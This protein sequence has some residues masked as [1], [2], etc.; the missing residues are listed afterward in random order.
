ME[1]T[2]EGETILN[3]DLKSIENWSKQWLVDFNPRKTVAMK[4]SLKTRPIPDPVL[5]FNDSQ[6]QIVASHKH[7]GLE[8][9]NK[10]NW[11]D[12]ITTIATKANRKLDN[13]K[14]LRF[15][16]DRKTLE[17]LYKSFIRPTIEYANIVWD[18]CDDECKLMLEKVQLDAARIVTGG[19]KGTSHR[20]LYKESGW[21][22]LQTRRDRQKILL[23]HKMIHNNAPE[24][25][26]NLV[27]SRVNENHGYGTRQ[28]ENSNYNMP[29]FRLEQYR[30][31]FLPETVRLWNA[32]PNEAK[33]INNFNQFK[34]KIQ[35]IKS[36]VNPN[37][38]YGSRYENIIHARF[39]MECSCLKD[40]LYKMHIIDNPTCLC[41]MSPETVS[42]YFFGCNLY[43]NQR[44][45]L[46]ETIE[47]VLEIEKEN[48]TL[49]ML[50]HGVDNW[51][52]EKNK[53]LFDS[54]HNYFKSTHR[55]ENG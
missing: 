30:K 27:P 22:S 5:N 44:Q 52:I 26:C 11:R 21:E 35:G 50:L 13:L 34:G 45:V 33:V 6:L 37:Y 15:K 2:L 28:T 19:I 24:Y 8:F 3:A 29:N 42:H 46:F 43:Q 17:V 54:I 25:L 32:L 48:I 38:Y 4:V 23:Y 53:V 55:F 20:A 18:N 10:L 40:H 49:E 9:N 7:L 12:H 31:S 1:N 36:K 51:D 47:N 16:L 14:R 41:G 39:R